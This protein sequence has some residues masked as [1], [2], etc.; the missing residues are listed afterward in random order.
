MIMGDRIVRLLISAVV[1]M[2]ISQ[3]LA[4]ESGLKLITIEELKALQNS[5]DEAEKV[6]TGRIKK[7]GNPNIPP[8]VKAKGKVIYEDTFGNLDNWHHE[9]RGMLSQPEPNLMQLECV[10]SKQ[11]SV[12]CMAFC[13]KDFPDNICIEYDLK[14]LTTN[15]LVITFIAAQGRHG[16]DMITGLPIREGIFADYVYNP[17]LRCYHVSV[18]RYNDEGVHTGVSN[19]RRNP[20]LFLMAQQPD[21]CK[22][23]N[24]WYHIAIIKQGRLLQM[25]V[26]GKLAGGFFDLDEIPEPVPKGGKIGFRAI[27]AKVLAQIKNFKVTAIDSTKAP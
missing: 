12:G 18:S 11:G 25:E 14:V 17:K 22:Q 10:D 19:W 21:L 3:A 13:R 6:K 16:E 24:I 15:G 4:Q 26:D 20:G 7:W 8:L 5:A 9:G 23:P 1:S 2:I 27:G